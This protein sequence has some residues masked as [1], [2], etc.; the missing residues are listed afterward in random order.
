[1]LQKLLDILGNYLLNYLL[2]LAER[3][4]RPFIALPFLCVE[5]GTRVSTGLA[6]LKLSQNGFTDIVRGSK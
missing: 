4:L 6:K 2:S 5:Y 3:Y 1:M